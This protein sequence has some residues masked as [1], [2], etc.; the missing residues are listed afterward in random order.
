MPSSPAITAG[1]TARDAIGALRVVLLAGLA[2]AAMGCERVQSFALDRA[3]D[4]VARGDRV[5]WLDDGNLHV[6]LCGTGSPLP[7]RDRAAACTAVIAGGKLWLVDVG[8]GSWENVQLWRLPRAAIGAVLLTHFHS[9]HIGELGEVSMQTWVAGRERPLR[10]Y[11][12]RGVMA[13]VGGFNLA[14]SHD[15]RYRVDHHGAQ[16]MPP[17]AAAMQPEM[18]E[19]ADGEAR[20]EVLEENGLK[21][22]AIRVDH[23]PVEP[24]Y[25]YRFDYGGRSVVISGDTKRSDVLVRNAQGA[26]ILVHEALAAHIIYPLSERLRERGIERMAKLTSDIPDYHTTPAQAAEVAAQAGV[27]MLVLTHLVPPLQ[28]AIARRVFQRGMNVRAGVEFVLGE[29]GDH[30]EL[31]AGGTGIAVDKLEDD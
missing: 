16:Y 8:P 13:V 12:P 26:D 20:A 24:A 17:T 3:A 6:V 1:G 19:I 27:R 10:V 4:R 31:D 2:L 14:Y 29:D 5:D 15:V 30:F 21:I 7:D 18:V 11:G 9:D 23:E 25:G 28:N 22:T